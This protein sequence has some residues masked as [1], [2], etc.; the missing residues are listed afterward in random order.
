M[1]FDDDKEYGREE[2]PR[3]QA[4]FSRRFRE[5]SQSNDASRPSESSGR[6]SRPPGGNYFEPEIH[7]EAKDASGRA[8]KGAVRK[9]T[10]EGQSRPMA[11]KAQ[12][13]DFGSFSARPPVN[14][15][16]LLRRRR[17]RRKR[18]FFFSLLFLLLL[19]L[20]GSAYGLFRIFTGGSSEKTL[21]ATTRT[22][23]ET[24]TPEEESSLAESESIAQLEAEKES[25]MEE[26]LSKANR[27]AAGYDYDKAI[28]LLQ[29]S[30]YSGEQRL[31]DA[32]AGFEETKKTL[33]RQDISTI[34]HVFFHIL[35]VDTDK[36]FDGDNKEAGYNQVMTTIGEFNAILQNMYDKGFVL[37]G[38]HDM[39]YEVEDPETGKMKMKA[40]DIML[41]PGKKAFVMSQDDV[42]YYEYMVGDGFASRLVIGDDGRVT[43]EMDL[44]D[45]TT[46][47]GPYDLIPILN[48]FI[49]AHPDFS[50][51]GAKAI[52][53]LTGYNG[54]FGYRTDADYA[55]KNPNFEEDKQKAREVAQALRD[56]GWEIASH[57]WGHRHLGRIDYDHF[58]ADSDK[59]EANVETLTGEVDILLYPFGTDVGDWRPYSEDNKRYKYLHDL[60]FRYFCN[61]DSAQHWVQLDDRFLRQGRRNL[62]GYRMWR[63]ISEPDNPKVSDLFDAKEI[64]DPARPTPVGGI[65]S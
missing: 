44:E 54:I 29:T 25:A 23:E 12:S 31:L 46:V 59:W 17:R 45:G 32:V 62:D 52:I 10:G 22:T 9:R 49:D 48:E 63:D 15:R 11:D 65:T 33:V 16:A 39:A 55:E 26:L 19:I 41:P 40:G 14:N 51:Q 43:T 28:E 5:M 27:L 13:S 60:G 47:T 6:R 24:R 2:E 50:Y 35:I 18:I 30:D 1:N 37:V 58:K 61:V 57:S 4:R 53:A 7:F 36:A 21:A 34:P 64:F 42:C 56:D 20:G 38:L 8:S 3:Q